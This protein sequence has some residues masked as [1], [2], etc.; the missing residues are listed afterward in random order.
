MPGAEL[1]LL[2][3][4]GAQERRGRSGMAGGNPQ[5]RFGWLNRSGW[6]RGILLNDGVGGIR[7]IDAA[8]WTKNS[9]RHLPVDRLDLKGK[10]RSATALNLDFHC[11]RIQQKDIRWKQQ[12]KGCFWLAP[13]CFAIE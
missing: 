3:G 2:V 8:L 7:G 11:L 13:F 12:I 1:N 9:G 5:S 10:T 6:R 4:L